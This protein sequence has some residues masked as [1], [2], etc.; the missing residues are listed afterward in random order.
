M[1]YINSYIYIY[2]H[3]Y[4]YIYQVPSLEPIMRIALLAM[5]SDTCFAITADMSLEQFI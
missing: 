1:I 4:T 3:I 5:A 2:I